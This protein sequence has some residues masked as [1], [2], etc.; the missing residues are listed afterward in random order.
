MEMTP[1]LR[2]GPYKIL[3]LLGSGGMG[4]VYLA[5]DE[6]L[7]RHVAL[8]VVSREPREGATRRVVREARTIARLN[9]P[10]IAGLY[11]VFEHEREA[12]LVMEYIEGEP[13]TALV[14]QQPVSIE[15]TLDIGLQLVDALRYA[16]R[17]RIIHRDIKPANVML[18]PEGKVKLLDLGLARVTPDPTAATQSQSE[19]APSD[20]QSRAGTPAY[21][22]PER[23]GRHVADARTDVYSVGVLLFE[24]LTGRRPYLAPDLMTLAVNVATHPTPRVADTRP[25][26]PPVLDDL[27]ARAMAKDPATRYASAAELHDA[28]VRVRETMTGRYPEP[29]DDSPKI[30]R[31]TVVIG[32][33]ILAVLAI[34]AWLVFRPGPS[35]PPVIGPGMCAIQPVINE[36]TDQADLEELGSLLHSVLSR[37]LG[38]VPGITIVP[39]QLPSATGQTAATGQPSPKPADYTMSIKI[40]RAVAG[41]A[42]D[43]DI[44]RNDNTRLVR[45]Q[46]SGDE[47]ALFRSVL[48]WL[49]TVV[50]R[51]S[52]S[53][54]K[55]SDAVLNQLRALPTPDRQALVSYL[56]GR[57]VLSTTDD[58][59]ADAQAVAAFQDAITR[60]GSFSFA[61]A[62]LSQAY[63]STWKHTLPRDRSL[64]ERAR[65]VAM[66][67][68]AIDQ[69]CDQA[70]VALA[71]AFSFLPRRNEAV[72]E[73]KRAVVLAPDN[74]DA[75]RA[76]GLALIIDAQTE[77][78]LVELRSALDRRP[79]RAINMYYVGYGLLRARRDQEA[80]AR[81]KKATEQQPNFESAW[82]NLGLAYLRVGDWEKS[83]GSS[84]RALELNKTDSDAVNNLA[85]AYY[86]DGKYELAVQRFQEAARLEPESPR[87]QMNLGDAL[88]AVGRFPEAK[89][90]YAR[91]VNLA[92]AE[93]R[94]RFDT[95]NAGIAAKSHAKLGNKAE[96]ELLAG[97]AWEA[98]DKDP[99]VVYKV[100]AVYAL[101]GQPAKALDKLELAVKLGKPLWEVQA[102]PDLTSLR[103]EVR[104]KNLT[105]KS[106]R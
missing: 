17:S 47:L 55:S 80:I 73:A 105:A 43:V 42:A 86:W 66:K 90:A 10:N 48:D 13:L 35:A 40:R 11:D 98:D 104:F 103:N 18:T 38:R 99:E 34:V 82:V 54:Q 21:M 76:L 7:D 106:G 52:G 19:S 67:A 25:D 58:L 61:H 16:H 71:L 89:K 81:L 2:L 14:K 45:Q 39:A 31:R 5:H 83:I 74:D 37:N 101:T 3:R 22:A 30:S 56:D 59:K 29:L 69:A 100:A 78:G 49:A 85:L 63:W 72:S 75:R 79:H 64:L 91:A 15:R 53:D 36:S 87:R 32:A 95:T 20:V 68:A 27:V 46:F 9:H 50:Q 102:D 26:I 62:G 65:D 24:L 60:D 93:L 94:K 1:G 44:L 96:A 41:L 84:S 70:H 77:A 88:D 57:R 92:T 33:G 4:A 6:R 12:F 51:P 97:Q 8:K 23:L 28:L